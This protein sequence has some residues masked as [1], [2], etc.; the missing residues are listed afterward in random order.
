MT[1]KNNHPRAR[2]TIEDIINKIDGGVL[3]YL[4]FA[5]AFTGC[6]TTSAIHRFGKLSI[7]K[8]LQ[9]SSELKNIA[10]KFHED[11]VL[12]DDIGNAMICFFEQMHSS[13]DKFP[14]IR[15]NKY[16][17]MVL[18]KRS[19]IDPALLPPPRASF[20]HG[21]RVYYQLKVWR[22]LRDTDFNPLDWRWKLQDQSF[23]PIMMAEEAGPPHILKI[24]RC[25]CNEVC[26]KRCSCRKSGLQCT[27]TC[28]Q[29]HIISCTNTTAEFDD[30]NDID[31]FDEDKNFLD[32]FI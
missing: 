13:I 14:Q 6:D 26:N 19:H 2:Y 15:K 29:C 3:E 18:S 17:E 31:K 22:D 4:L 27:S 28:K 1:R 12:P 20:F 32:A 23:V 11:S 9:S 30:A 5:H 25:G 10:N 24:I 16:D 7:F 21:L 8:K